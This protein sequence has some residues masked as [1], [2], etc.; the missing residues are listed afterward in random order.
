MPEYEEGPVVQICQPHEVAATSKALG[1]PVS[2]DDPDDP[3]H[4]PSCGGCGGR[5]TSD[6]CPY[7][8]RIARYV[9]GL[10]H[11]PTGGAA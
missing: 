3:Y 5:D 6:T 10:P 7:S 1:L 4:H 11:P 9:A 8:V 2:S